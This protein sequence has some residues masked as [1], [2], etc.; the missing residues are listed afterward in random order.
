MMKTLNYYN[1][2]DRAIFSVIHI[3]AVIRTSSA[4]CYRVSFYRPVN[5]GFHSKRQSV[6]VA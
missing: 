1:G 2:A 6:K 3:F 5:E 4:L